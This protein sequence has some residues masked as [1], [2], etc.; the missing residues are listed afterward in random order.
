MYISN[1]LS[2]VPVKANGSS[3]VQHWSP[4]GGRLIGGAHGDIPG[5][6]PAT[7]IDHGRLGFL[8]GAGD[9]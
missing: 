7:G 9:G 5:G 4:Q 1:D 8:G 6:G 2:H 3:A